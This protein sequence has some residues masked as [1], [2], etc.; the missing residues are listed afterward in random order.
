M[1]FF[2]KKKKITAKFFKEKL[3][4]TRTINN[5]INT[6]PIF[7]AK[8]I[9]KRAIPVQIETKRRNQLSSSKSTLTICSTFSDRSSLA[10]R[11][12]S[13]LGKHVCAEF[14][15]ALKFT[16]VFTRTLLVA[17]SPL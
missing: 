13:R 10:P 14:Y 15:G 16:L 6:S 3:Y 8:F 2:T 5:S 4:Y 17:P 9:T 12:R 1:K 11:Q 7:A